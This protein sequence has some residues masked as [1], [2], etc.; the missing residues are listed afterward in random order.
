MEPTTGDRDRDRTTAESVAEESSELK[1][2]ASEQAGELATTARQQA[3]DVAREAAEQG[4][5]LIDKAKAGV[6][7]QARARTAEVGQSLHRLGGEVQALAD[8]R[9]QD[10][11]PLAGYVRD[12][13]SKVED[14]AH[15]IEAEGFDGIL[16]DVAEFGRRR[17]GVFLLVAGAAG[18][19]AGRAIRAGREN[20]ESV[21]GNGR[22]LPLAPSGLGA[23]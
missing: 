20:A 16:E 7:E 9:P 11:G 23:R 10:A 19:L 17:P 2:V 14:V 4:R 1:A 21:A 18:F 15:R 22:P 8:G 5:Q 6:Q 13:A 3:D 12:A